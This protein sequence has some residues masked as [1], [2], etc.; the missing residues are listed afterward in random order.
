MLSIPGEPLS[1]TA[2]TLFYIGGF[3]VTNTMTM[4]VL[5]LIF[6]ILLCIAAQRFTVRKPG[7]FQLMLENALLMITSLI[8]QVVGDRKVAWR[9]M[10]LVTTLVVFI[11]V[12][13]LIMTILPILTGFTYEGAPLF[14]SH[15]N[16]FNTTLALS[17]GMI[18]LIQVVS[19]AKNNPIGHILRYIPLDKVV[20][21]F[22]KGI[23]AGVMSFIDVFIGI[24]DIVSEIA[25]IVSL[26][27]RLFGN[28]FAGE[29]LVGILMGM[30]AIAL[31][32]PII[33]L[34]TLSGV[35]QAIVFGSLTASFLSGV[36]KD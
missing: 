2:P 34:A 16:D 32:V 9:I 11:L 24:L 26:S 21:G 33:G 10:P 17:F 8:E 5:N 29:L 7:K 23:G 31:P 20:A 28:M 25:R 30:L 19:I 6:F 12:S 35:I 36:L 13:N 14:R 18:V 4:A 3:P 15:T 27:L 22:R 1:V